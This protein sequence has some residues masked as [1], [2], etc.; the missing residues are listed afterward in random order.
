MNKRIRN[1][2]LNI[3]NTLYN[4]YGP[5]HWWP[6]DSPFE[7]AVG[8]ILTQNTNWG[9][10][11]KAINNL[12]SSNLLGARAINKISEAELGGIIRPSGYFNIKAKRLKSFISFLV[13]NFDGQIENMALIE[14]M[15][16]RTILL[17]VNG[18]GPETADSLILY[19][20]NKPLFVIDVYTKRII[21]RHGLMDYNST[22]D[23]FQRL[24]HENI[25]M[26]VKL[27]NEFHALFVMTGKDYC[28]PSPKC[29]G[30]N[31]CPLSRYLKC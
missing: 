21:S 19:A 4:A 6:G 10:V 31:P 13:N 29:L 30:G 7:I 23:D 17:N 28:K 20:V 15:K 22:Y 25:D 26:D 18:I 14:T 27:Y 24:F 1:K 16:L 2:L 12:K 11:V 3:Y 8:A 9:N 5:Q